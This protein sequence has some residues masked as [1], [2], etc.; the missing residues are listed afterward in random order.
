MV[1]IV[2]GAVAGGVWPSSSSVSPTGPCEAE[3][4]RLAFLIS[5]IG[6]SFFLYNL[7]GKEFGR[8]PVSIPAPFNLNGTVFT[9]F[10]A[11]GPDLRHRDRD[12]GH[13]RCWSSST[14][15]WP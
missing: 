13:R 9:V 8:N 10:G 1:G 7:A 6:A 15:W 12:L 4:P 5:A 11:P 2:G 14:A 3:R